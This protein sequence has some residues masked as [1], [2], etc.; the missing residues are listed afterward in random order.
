MAPIEAESRVCGRQTK[1]KRNLRR[2]V[3]GRAASNEVS[4]EEKEEK[5][6]YDSG[7]AREEEEKGVEEV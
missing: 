2:P 1:P 3:F 7:G 4:K 6:E 5:E